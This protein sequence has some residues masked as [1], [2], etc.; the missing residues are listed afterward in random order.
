M[1]RLSLALEYA[2][3]PT[4]FVARTLQVYLSPR[5]R[6]AIAV[7]L[8]HAPPLQTEVADNAG[9]VATSV[10]KLTFVHSMSYETIVLPPSVAGAVHAAFTVPIPA[11]PV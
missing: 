9:A 5:V 10:P 1:R 8:L 4:E 2:E 6:P 7:L 3:E 11:V